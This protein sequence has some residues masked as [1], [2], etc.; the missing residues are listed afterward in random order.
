M[1]YNGG[2]SKNEMHGN[3]EIKW[4]DGRRYEGNF[5]NDKMHSVEGDDTIP[6]VYEWPDGSK[7]IG[8]WKN[9]KQ[10]GRGLMLNAN[11]KE[12]NG[13]WILGKLMMDNFEV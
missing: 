8:K 3:G 2:W 11:G 7:Y 9:D 12:I 13:N 4:P 5:V 1:E 10:H 6:D